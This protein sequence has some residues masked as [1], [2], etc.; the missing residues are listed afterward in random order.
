MKPASSTPTALVLIDIQHGFS[1]VVED[2]P[3]FERNITTLLGA[4]REYNARSPDQPILIIHV[5][6]HSLDPTSTL[7][8]S[9]KLPSGTLGLKPL[10]FARPLTSE[11]VLTKHHNSSFVG[12]NLEGRLREFGAR[13]LILA[14]LTTDHCV[15]TTSRFA[16]NLQVLG[17]DGGPDGTG[18]G[19]NGIILLRDGTATYA[20]GAF[21]AETLHEVHLAS[22]DEEFVQVSGTDEAIAAIIG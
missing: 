5:H 7:H 18:L 15:S 19:H 3:Y 12:T 2:T 9:Y 20:K 6:H 17:D 8:P 21:D 14:G 11:P 4:A 13:Q 22:L 10:D 1:S 16:A